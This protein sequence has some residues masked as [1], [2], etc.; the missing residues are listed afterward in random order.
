MYKNY[1]G[2][3]DDDTLLILAEQNPSI[4][5]DSYLLLKETG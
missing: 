1:T 4:G 3:V 2:D 5:N